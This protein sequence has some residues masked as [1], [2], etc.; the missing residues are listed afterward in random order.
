MS[1]RDEYPLEN[2][3]GGQLWT[4][5]SLTSTADSIYFDQKSEL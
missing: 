3:E 2:I 4:P 5:K 1:G